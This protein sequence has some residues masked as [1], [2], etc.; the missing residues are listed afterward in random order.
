MAVRVNAGLGEI[1]FADMHPLVHGLPTPER[2]TA[3]R[4]FYPQDV[5]SP[6]PDRSQFGRSDAVQSP[7]DLHPSFSAMLQAAER[8]GAV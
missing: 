5:G 4:H 7:P 1:W 2:N 8:L 3:I 6:D